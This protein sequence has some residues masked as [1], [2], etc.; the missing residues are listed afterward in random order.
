MTLDLR[1]DDGLESGGLLGRVHPPLQATQAEL[2]CRKTG[3]QPVTETRKHLP[4]LM[5]WGGGDTSVSCS[6]TGGQQ[7]VSGNHIRFPDPYDVHPLSDGFVLQQDN[8][9]PHVSALSR[10]FF[11]RE[12]VEVLDRPA[13]S[14]DLNPVENLWAIIEKKFAPQKRTSSADWKERVAVVWE[15]ID[16]ELVVELVRSMPNRIAA[17]IKK[18]GDHTDY[19]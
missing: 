10:H 7:Q 5:I 3:K 9:S 18:K 19:Y 4:S 16:Q 12:K 17:C 8:A 13:Q 2:L 1:K 11:D 15:D 6:W 14:P